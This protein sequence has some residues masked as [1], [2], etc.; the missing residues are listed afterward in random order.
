MGSSATETEQQ[1]IPKTEQVP[2]LTQRKGVV[3]AQVP[4]RL[5][6]DDGHEVV[7]PSCTFYL[8]RA[9]LEVTA[10]IPKITVINCF[11]TQIAQIPIFAVFPMSALCVR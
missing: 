5:V 6:T 10:S 4:A 8:A 11:M 9:V 2:K 7:A 3:L 1:S